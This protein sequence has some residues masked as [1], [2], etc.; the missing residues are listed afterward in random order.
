MIRIAL[1]IATV[2]VASL[3]H[4]QT[5]E[6]RYIYDELGRL[7]AVIA[8]P[9]EAAVYTYDA[10][11]N[12]LSITRPPAGTVS[13]LEFSPNAGPTGSVVTISGTGFS[14]TASQNTV[15]FNGVTATVLSASSNMLTVTVPASATSGPINVTT[16]GGSATSAEPFAVTAGSAPTITGFSPAIVAPSS[17]VTITGTNFQPTLT[18][19]RLSFNVTFGQVN[20][21]TPTTLG[22]TVPALG[23]TGRIALVTPGG[24]ATTASYLWVAPPPYVATDVTGTA[25]LTLGVAATA[26]VGTAG[27]IAL[28]AI[29]AAAGQRIAVN[30]SDTITTYNDITVKDPV[31][32]NVGSTTVSSSPVFF[33]TVAVTKTGTVTV[34][35]DP[36][37]SGTGDVTA[38]AYVFADVSATVTAGGPPVTVSTTVPGQQVRVTF[39]GTTGQRVALQ[40]TGGTMGAPY[41]SIVNPDGSVLAAAFAYNSA[42]FFDTM[43]L[44]NGLYTVLIDPSGTATGNISLLLHVVPADV[45]GS[46]VAGG[47]SQNL[48]IATPGQ[49]GVLTFTG[50]AGQRVSLL[51]PNPAM[52]GC[53]DVSIR[54]PAPDE[55]VLASDFCVA[56]V[57]RFLDTV[58]LPTSGLYR[59]VVN[60]STSHTGSLTLTLHDVPPDLNLTIAA[61][62]VAVNA[63]FTVP[64]Q[65]GVLTFTGTTGQRVSLWVASGTLQGCTDV[66][67]RGPVP[68][69]TVVTSYYCPHVSG[70]LFEP[71]TLPAG[72]TYRIE[73]NPSAANTGARAF[74]LYTVPADATG[75]VSVQGAQVALLIPGQQAHLTFAGTQGQTVQ[76]HVGTPGTGCTT[77]TL[78]RADETT[79]LQTRFWCSEPFSLPVVTLPATETYHV[80]V[81]PNTNLTG[82]FVVTFL[83]PLVLV[84]GVAAPTGVT[85]SPG[86]SVTVSVSGGPA[87]RRDWVTLAVTGSGYGSYTTFQYLNG[88][89]T[90]PA[91]SPSQSSATLTF[92]MPTT[93]GTYVFRLFQDGGFTLLAA[94]TTVTVQ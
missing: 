63:S 67:I 40:L 88:T 33:D 73:V 25:A 51:M 81:D 41:V 72:G 2:C 23:T 84:N 74:T 91:S 15:T 20:T 66:T 64:G 62:G 42:G 35:V 1:V 7:V 14:T 4:A 45:S 60:P 21:A 24:A 47:A 71:F 8:P 26:T 75:T 43:T 83:A 52:T 59:L 58:T 12:L 48:T 77:L 10:V 70:Y 79:V 86:A 30:V 54:K 76:V 94:S 92:T 69:T 90:P 38:T 82:Q 37:G 65:N 46:I 13:I 17:G 89:Q 36:Q 28:F 57:T 50:S 78:L 68:A 22:A 5:A 3:A 9:G 27:K 56:S 85:V 87:F 31:G 61:D 39:Q 49:N 11:G 80:R 18:N 44:G 34:L 16:P 32:A 6:V 55:T 19:N 53:T 29:D 93:P